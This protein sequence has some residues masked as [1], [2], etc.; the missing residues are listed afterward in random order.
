VHISTDAAPL[1]AEL[2]E[3]KKKKKVGDGKDVEGLFA[4]MDL[5]EDESKG[6]TSPSPAAAPAGLD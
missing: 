1:V 6:G 5:K 2:G 4:A 3:K